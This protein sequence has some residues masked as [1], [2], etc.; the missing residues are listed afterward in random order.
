MSAPVARAQEPSAP[1]WPQSP[2]KAADPPL[3]PSPNQGPATSTSGTDVV[4][5]GGLGT[6]PPVVVTDPRGDHGRVRDLENRLALDEAR[7]KTL[8]DDVGLLRHIKVQGYVQLQYRMQS[9]NA[10]G[11][12][13]L[14]NGTLP[15]GIGPNDVIARSDGTTTNTNLFRLRRTRLRTIYETDVMRVFLQIDLLPAGGPSAAQGTIARNAE[16]TG[17]AHWSK[18]VKTEF[19]GGL[20]QVP[21]SAEVLES[22]MYRPFIERTWMSQNLFPTERDLGVHA[23]TSIVKDR[24]AIDVGMLNGKRLGEKL[25]VLLPDLNR[26]KDFFAMAQSK[27]GPMLFTLAGYAGTSEVVDTER[28]RV[29]NFGRRAMNVGVTFTKKLVPSLGDTKLMGEIMW[30]TN[31]DTGVNYA[32]SRP[33]IPAN[34]TDDVTDLHQRGFYLRAEQELTRW[35]IAGFRFDQYSTDTSIDNNA[36]N[37]YTFMAGARFSK[38][39]RLIN[40]ASYAVDNMHAAGTTAPSI[41][42]FGYTAW[43]QGSFY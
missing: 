19:T 7:L 23:R 41:H 38:L 8:E 36:R 3:I 34:F 9:V 10:A 22:S 20:F 6:A 28:L 25:F 21:F 30:G 29:K 39:L 33:A 37:T 27:V 31:M 26:S 13:N 42:V 18:H 4:P 2:A 35:A 43:L 11:S 1:Q 40:E 16:A 14:V 17:I 24:L 5:P 12:P 15:Q 32:F